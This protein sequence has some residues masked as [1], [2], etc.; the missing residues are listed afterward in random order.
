MA[1]HDGVSIEDAKKLPGRGPSSMRNSQSTFM[2][3]R[4]RLMAAV[5][6]IAIAG[7]VGIGAVTTGTV[8]VF[9]EAVRVEAPQAPGFADVVERVSPAVVSVRVKSSIE[10]TSDGGADWSQ[11]PPGFDDLPD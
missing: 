11:L 9:A 7:S 8:P 6:S 5:A 4:K 1:P 3:A 2:T 10:S